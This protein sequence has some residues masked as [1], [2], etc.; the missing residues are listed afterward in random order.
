[1]MSHACESIGESIAV[2]Q[3]VECDGAF[4]KAV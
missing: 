3:I 2:I 1:M 4:D